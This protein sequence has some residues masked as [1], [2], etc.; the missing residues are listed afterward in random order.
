MHHPMSSEMP[1]GDNARYWTRLDTRGA[2]SANS[3]DAIRQEERLR[4]SPSDRRYLGEEHV[5]AV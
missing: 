3:S 2:E 5:P 4:L 1:G